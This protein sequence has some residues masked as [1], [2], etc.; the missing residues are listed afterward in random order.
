[1]SRLASILW[2]EVPVLASADRTGS[3]GRAVAIDETASEA[4]VRNDTQMK[5]RDLAIG[6]TDHQITV[7]SKVRLAFPVFCN[8]L[9]SRKSN[10]DTP[11]ASA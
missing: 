8:N 9:E 7:I 4:A 11:T 6:P 10:H 5:N 3:S 2:I 1:L